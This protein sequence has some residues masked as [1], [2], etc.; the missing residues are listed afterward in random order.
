[1]FSEAVIRYQNAVNASSTTKLFGNEIKLES[2]DS[3]ATMQLDCRDG[4]SV[5]V[6]IR[7]ATYDVSL[8][9][10]YDES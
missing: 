6:Y 9:N 7:E 2:T 1:M 10:R 5:K 4:I 8:V 3:S